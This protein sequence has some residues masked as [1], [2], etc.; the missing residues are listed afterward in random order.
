MNRTGEGSSFAAP[1]L[2]NF[3]PVTHGLR[4][5][6]HSSAASRLVVVNPHSLVVINP[7][8]PSLV[9]ANPGLHSLVAVNPGLPSLVDLNPGLRSHLVVNSGLLSLVVVNPGL[10]SLVVVD[11][12][13]GH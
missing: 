2:G 7:G 3:S 6:L 12:F 8:L 5:G 10:R 11:R 4:R 1:R 9:A 13:I